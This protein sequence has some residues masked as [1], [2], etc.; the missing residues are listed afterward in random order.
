ML[1]LVRRLLA[2]LLI[3]IFE[4]QPNYPLPYEAS[5][6]PLIYLSKNARVHR[7]RG[8]AYSLLSFGVIIA[9]VG[10]LLH[11]V[12]KISPIPHADTTVTQIYY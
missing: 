5:S 10:L 11:V 6:I 2:L 7:M 3:F 8:S 1:H 12:L 4:H 9:I